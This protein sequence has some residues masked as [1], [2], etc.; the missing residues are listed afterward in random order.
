MTQAVDCAEALITARHARGPTVAGSCWLKLSVG[1][2]LTWHCSSFE[3]TML[4]GL[5]Q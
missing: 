1:V 4:P 5:G 3:Q 2:C